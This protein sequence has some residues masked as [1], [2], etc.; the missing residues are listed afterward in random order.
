MKP[1]TLPF[2][3]PGT[4]PASNGKRYSFGE[5]EFAEIAEYDPALRPAPIV[6]SHDLRGEADEAQIL[7]RQELAFGV[8]DGVIREGDT[9]KAR[10]TKFAPQLTTWLKEGR[11]NQISA[12]FFAPDDPINPK[13][14]K[15][16]LRHIALLGVSPQAMTGL[17]GPEFSQ[18]NPEESMND[19]IELEFAAKSGGKK[20]ACTKGWS[21]GGTCITRTKKCPS[22]LGN[23]AKS[24]AGYLRRQIA[25]SAKELKKRKDTVADWAKPIRSLEGVKRVNTIETKRLAQNYRARARMQEREI[26]KKDAEISKQEASKLTDGRVVGSPSNKQRSDRKR[27]N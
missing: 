15:Y 6:V 16:Y 20:R 3:I 11:L 19:G 8:I 22:A 13:P 7:N 27:R 18:F 2:L 25:T 23:E 12:K 4:H 17:P 1:L 10:A 14:G 5:K 26:A 9:L 21:C 24:Y